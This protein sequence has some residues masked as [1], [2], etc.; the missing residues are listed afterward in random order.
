MSKGIDLLLS[1]RDITNTLYNYAKACDEKDWLLLDS[2]FYESAIAIYGDPDGYE[3]NG[4]KEIKS[5]LAESLQPVGD[6]QHS[7]TNLQIK[8]SENNAYVTSYLA[9][10]Q[11]SNDISADPTQVWGKYQDHL[12]LENGAWKIIKKKLKI[13]FSK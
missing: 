11:M 12:V 1:E 9:A 3:C 2:V 6:A 8:I 7:L 4:L 13:F 10:M 5:F